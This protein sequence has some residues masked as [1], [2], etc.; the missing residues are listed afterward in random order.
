[1]ADFETDTLPLIVLAAGRSS[2][3]RGAD[4]LLES[5]DGKP[6]IRRQAEIARAATKGAVIVTLPCNAPARLKAI[7]GCDVN[8][9]PVP[10]A[11]EGMSASLRR[12]LT[13]LPNDVPAAMVLLSDLPELTSADL[14]RVRDAVDVNSPTLIWRGATAQG[15]PGHPVVFANCLFH[16]LC[17]LSGDTG[18]AEV[19]ARH[20]DQTCLV[21]LPK[22]HARRD[23][24]T[25]EDW[26]AWRAQQ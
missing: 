9:I 15:A 21:P 13:A 2:R 7:E 26:A 25:P 18:G 6:L 14:I 22:E 5:V 12:A 10:D 20:R 8:V 17:A 16:E 24:D 4:K 19:V 23:L 11:A 3:M 1:M